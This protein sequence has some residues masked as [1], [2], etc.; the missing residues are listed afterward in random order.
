MTDRHLKVLI[1]TCIG[2]AAE[3]WMIGIHL[4]FQGNEL[5]IIE[6]TPTLI[7]RGTKGFLCEMLT[8]WLK[9]FPPNHPLPTIGK[10]AKAL[11]KVGE[12][13][14]AHNLEERLR[15]MLK[16]FCP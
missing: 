13:S 15:S 10:L 9:W 5:K 2:A 16:L 7:P 3:W 8:K 6:N 1:D 12:E 14:L 11:R 4:G